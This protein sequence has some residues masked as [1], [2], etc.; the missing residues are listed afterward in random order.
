VLAVTEQLQIVDVFLFTH[1]D[2]LMESTTTIL[3][4]GVMSVRN[5]NVIAV[6]IVVRNLVVHVVGNVK[7]T[8][9]LL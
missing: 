1:Q 3:I 5:K 4:M 6:V 8:L 2:L 7:L 9:V